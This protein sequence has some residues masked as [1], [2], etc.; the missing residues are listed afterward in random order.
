M[1]SDFYRDELIFK[2]LGF[3]DILLSEFEQQR[4]SAYRKFFKASRCM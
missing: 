1:S 3:D 4:I 2:E